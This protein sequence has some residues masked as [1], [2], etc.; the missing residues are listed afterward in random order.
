VSVAGVADDPRLDP[1]VKWALRNVPVTSLGDIDSRELLLEISNSP[2]AI[3]LRDK[4]EA[5]YD[6]LDTEDV[7]PSDGLSI[8]V[9]EF[10]SAPDGNTV[11]IRFVRPEGDDVVPCVYYLHGGGMQNGTAFGAMYRVWARVLAAE[12][13]PSRWSTSA[14]V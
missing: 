14:T 6:T 2:K 11:K 5:L 12:G 10:V 13:S 1:R 9:H 4:M 8:S 7:A 3:A